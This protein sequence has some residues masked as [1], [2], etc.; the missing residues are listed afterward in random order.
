LEKRVKRDVRLN[1]KGYKEIYSRIGRRFIS[2]E[3]ASRTEIEAICRLNGIEDA[4]AIRDI[5]TEAEGD[6]RRVKRKVYALKTV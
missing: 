1:K 5:I 6:L 3:P 4:T 2:L